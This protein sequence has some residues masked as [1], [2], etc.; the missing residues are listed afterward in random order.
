MPIF[1]AQIFGISLRIYYICIVIKNNNKMK[2]EIKQAS[3]GK[4][5]LVSNQFKVGDIVAIHSR[6]TGEELYQA[7]I[8]DYT[9]NQ[10]GHFATLF[11]ADGYYVGNTLGTALVIDKKEPRYNVVRKFTN[12]YAKGMGIRYE[13][14]AFNLSLADADKEKENMNLYHLDDCTDYFFVELSK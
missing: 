9:K 7:E 1:F 4:E 8:K 3:N 10:E 14:V 12:E 11:N 6:V 5:Y 2:K 13:R